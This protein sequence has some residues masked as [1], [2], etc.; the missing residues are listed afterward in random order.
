MKY[1]IYTLSLI[2]HSYVGG[3]LP[4]FLI[5]VVI[6]SIYGGKIGGGP[7]LIITLIS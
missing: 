1:G 3:N 2:A 4:S 7:I 5:S 6:S